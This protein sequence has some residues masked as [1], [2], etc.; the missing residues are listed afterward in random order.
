M[1][2]KE[3]QDHLTPRSADEETEAQRGPVTCPGSHSLS[4]AEQAVGFCL[5]LRLIWST[6]K[7]SR[8]GNS[9][10]RPGETCFPNSPFGQAGGW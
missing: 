5:V 4:K 8:R 1:S 2:K 10:A 3:L 7:A 6:S 9:N